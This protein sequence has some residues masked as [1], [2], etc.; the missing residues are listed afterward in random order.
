MAGF[1]TSGMTARKEVVK[2][3]GQ[4]SQLQKLPEKCFVGGTAEEEQDDAKRSNWLKD[5]VWAAVSRG[6]PLLDVPI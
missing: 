1:K 3:E 4:Q 2:E 5:S 6:I